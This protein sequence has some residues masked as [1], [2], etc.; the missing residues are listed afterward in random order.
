VHDAVKTVFCGSFN[1]CPHISVGVIPGAADDVKAL[2]LKEKRGSERIF[3]G[4]VFPV[5]NEDS[6]VCLF[7]KKPLDLLVFAVKVVFIIA[8]AVIVKEHISPDDGAASLG[9]KLRDWGD[10][11]LTWKA[12][13]TDD[14]EKF[15]AELVLVVGLLKDELR[16]REENAVK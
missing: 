4:V 7:K 14:L 2:L 1:V 16:S 10:N 15:R 5:G 8:L 13:E 9:E 12:L 6:A 11:P 3:C